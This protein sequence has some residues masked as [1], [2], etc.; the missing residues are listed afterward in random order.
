MDP[1]YFARANRQQ[2]W[3][4]KTVVIVFAGFCNFILPLVVLADAPLE[5]LEI[6]IGELTA[7]LDDQ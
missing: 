2:S 5:Q 6:N 3:L 1:R 7:I 4:L